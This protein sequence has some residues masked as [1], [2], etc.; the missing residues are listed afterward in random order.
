MQISKYLK[1]SCRCG[2]RNRGLLCFLRADGGQRH[3]RKLDRD[4]SGG[5][6]IVWPQ[7]VPSSQGGTV[8][9]R[10][11]TSGISAGLQFKR[12]PEGTLQNPKPCFR[13]QDGCS[14]L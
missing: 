9:Q 1:I 6:E 8:R 3:Q 11:R 12:G 5:V 2:A 4:S 14:L 10:T 7:A 13:L